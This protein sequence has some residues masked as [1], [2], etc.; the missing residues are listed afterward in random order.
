MP[1]FYNKEIVIFDNKKKK[2]ELTQSNH[3]CITVLQYG[4]E[5]EDKK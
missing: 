2:N 5:I 4:S 3:W 1:Q